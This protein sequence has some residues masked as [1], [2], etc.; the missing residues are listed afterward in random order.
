ML[1][2]VLPLLLFLP[3]SSLLAGPT[4]PADRFQPNPERSA[5]LGP[6]VPDQARVDGKYVGLLRILKVP[7]DRASYPAFHDFG[8]WGGTEWAGHRNL[9]AGY[10][11]YVYPNWY[12]WRDQTPGR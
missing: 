12:I 6:V 10:W 3:V 2:W 7:Q 4:R 8:Q 9:P 5:P 1:R 11:V